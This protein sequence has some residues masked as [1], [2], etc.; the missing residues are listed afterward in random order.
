MLP[1]KGLR[2][3]FEKKKKNQKKLHNINAQD[4]LG[5]QFGVHLITLY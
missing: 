4:D 5:L 3:R 2:L 1:P